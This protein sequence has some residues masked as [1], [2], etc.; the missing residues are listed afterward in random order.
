MELVL[1]RTFKGD[2]Y[3]IG[4]LYCKVYSD[5]QYASGKGFELMYICDTLEDVDRGLNKDMALTEISKIKIKSKTAIPTGT[6]SVTLDI[7]SPKFSNYKQYSFCNGYLPR[8]VG[9]PGY[10][11]VLIHIGNTTQDTDGCI[12]VGQNKVKGQVINST[13]TF[14]E[15]YQTLKMHADIHEP[16]YI[17]I[18]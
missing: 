4:K 12:L 8:L 15:L 14:K 3:T 17:T 5:E 11:G 9:V 18:E 10:D 6:Y 1:K 13:N 16:I 7:Q 2:K